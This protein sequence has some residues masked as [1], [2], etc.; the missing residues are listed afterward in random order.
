MQMP[1][2]PEP[3]PEALNERGNS[4]AAVQPGVVLSFESQ[5]KLRSLYGYVDSCRLALDEIHRDL[6]L[7]RSGPDVL[8]NLQGASERLERFCIEAD[9]WG[10]NALYE[11]ALG[12]QMLVLN[13][14]IRVQSSGFRELLQRGLSMLAALLD[15][16]E[17]DFC[18]RLAIADMLESIDQAGRN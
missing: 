17:R 2:S 7:D 3:T 13:L 8:M 11:I 18:W 5:L 1:I 9:S 12:L 4:D 14:G 6:S 16:C 10:F 15:Q